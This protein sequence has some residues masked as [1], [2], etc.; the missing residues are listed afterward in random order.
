MQWTSLIFQNEILD[1]ITEVVLDSIGNVKECSVNSI[2]V[3]EMSVWWISL[4]MSHKPF[5]NDI[6]SIMFGGEKIS[7]RHLNLSVTRWSCR[8]KNKN[9]GR[10]I[11]SYHKG[12][13]WFDKL[14]KS[15]KAHRWQ[16]IIEYNIQF[17]LHN[18]I[19]CAENNT[20]KYRFGK[21][22]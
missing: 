14:W 19:G 4:N 5:S 7:H 15:P 18:W 21:Y 12:I 3:N 1:I 20:V 13:A 17:Q 8:Y 9:C 16:C 10:E 22:I 11:T 6:G 2:I